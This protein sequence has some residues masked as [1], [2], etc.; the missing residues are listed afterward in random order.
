MAVI[1]YAAMISH[2]GLIRIF[3]GLADG[4]YDQLYVRDNLYLGNDV[5]FNISFLDNFLMKDG[6]IFDLF[7][8]DGDVFGDH[9]SIIFNLSTMYFFDF[10]TYFDNGMFYLEILS[11]GVLKDNPTA[12]VSEPRV[13]LLMLL[14]ILLLLFTTSRKRQ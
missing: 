11:D 9:S 4:L 12:N 13:E 7:I 14:S 10:Q 5:I 2:R 1:Y 3:P 6:D 8:I